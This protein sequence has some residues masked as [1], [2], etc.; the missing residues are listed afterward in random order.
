VGDI[1]LGHTDGECEDCLFLNIWT[2]SLEHKK[3]P[4]MFFLHGGAALYGSGSQA[5]YRGNLL[6]EK[7]DVVVVTIN[8]RMGV[9]GNLTHPGLRDAQGHVGNW[10]LLDMIAALKWVR[11]NIAAFGE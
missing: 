8:Y 9:F 1:V 3:R 6:C 4:V 10:G 2:P 5:F 11:N 7:G